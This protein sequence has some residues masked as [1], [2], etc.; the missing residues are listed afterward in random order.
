M[1]RAEEQN[2]GEAELGDQLDRLAARIAE[3]DHSL[4]GGAV[5]GE[6]AF[7]AVLPLRLDRGR[8]ERLHARDALDEQRVVGGAT[9]ELL[10]EPAAQGTGDDDRDDHISGKGERDDDEEEWRVEEH[11]DEEDDREQRI[12]Q[13]GERRA[14]H[15]F[16]HRLQLADA[17]NGVADAAILEIG[18]RQTEQ[19]A[20]EAAAQL[21]V[22]LLAGLRIESSAQPAECDFP[23][24]DQNEPDTE[25]LQRCQAVVCQHLVDNVLEEERRGET[26]QVE[27]EGDQ[28][29]FADQLS[30]FDDLGDEPGHVEGGRGNLRGIAGGDEEQRA[31][32]S[33]LQHGA[34]PALDRGTG[35]LD[36]H[37]ILADA[38]DH[39]PAFGAARHHRHG[40]AP[41]P[42]EIAGRG[43]GADAFD[44]LCQA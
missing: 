42:F 26:E 21:D 5:R 12:D 22:E 43:A 24:R 6:L 35:A 7:P 33:G 28:Q 9:R 17:G 40:K 13:H 4:V 19:M 29:D 1:L 23:E 37:G 10:V 3:V 30:V 15:E 25:H 18:E 39:E 31:R 2:R 44:A 36:R 20:E 38:A 8:L 27:R 34:V 41:Q 32:P 11:R 16:A 14:G